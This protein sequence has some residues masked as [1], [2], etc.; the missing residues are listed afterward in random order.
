MKRL[1]LAL[2][3]MLLLVVTAA[4]EAHPT[5]N[6][7]V[8][9]R[10][11][12]DGR[13]DVEITAHA[14]S[15]ALTL[16]GLARDSALAHAAAASP[17][18]SPRDRINGLAPELLRLIELESDGSLVALKWLGVADTRDRQ[19]LVTVHLEG[20][21][22][23]RAETIRWRARF[24][25]AAYPIAVLGGTSTV[26]PDNYDWLAGDER[27]RVYRL[28][29]LAADESAWHSAVRL[30]PTGFTHIVPGGLD[31]VLFMLGLFLMASTR[32]ALLLQVS[33][34]TAAHSLTL[35]LGAFGA[36]HVPPQIVEPLIAASIAFIAL[37]NLFVTSVTRWRLLVVFVFGLLHGLGFA[38]AM[39]D[40]GL[41][42]EH[43][44]ASLVG[45][46]VGVELGQLAVIAS[47]A[48]IVRALRLSID[49]ERQFVLRPVSAAIALT[50]LFWAIQ[51][52]IQ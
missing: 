45:F 15:L 14:E 47:A 33:T 26:A 29:A 5:A 18:D 36:V 11:P 42:G 30:V 21:L 32:R 28:D 7:F 8:I 39:A 16:A 17:S 13:I 9:I 12:G 41:S 49:A 1:L 23:V 46:N 27:S 3:A 40:L 43:L 44:A 22:P 34:F 48:L 10:V 31:H 52:T 20:S 51:R 50:G 25:L 35:A 4:P 38:G 24:M 19:G 37:E 2:G 6:A